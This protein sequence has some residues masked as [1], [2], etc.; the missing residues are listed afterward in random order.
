MMVAP[1]PFAAL[2]ASEHGLLVAG[3]AFVGLAVAALVYPFV[4]AYTQPRR[5]EYRPP[6]EVRR[7]KR[8]REGNATFRLF[9]PLVDELAAS[10]APPPRVLDRMQHDL[11]LTEPAA[12]WKAAEYFAIR[13]IESTY[14]AGG[15]ALLGYVIFDNLLLAIPIG[16]VGAYVYPFLQLQLLTGRA[17][18]Y[19]LAL[20]SRLSLVADLV[21][22]ML[23][24]AATLPQAIRTAAEENRGH[25][26][27]DELARVQQAVEKME[28]PKDALW[29]MA[30][31][32]ESPDLSELVFM[33]KTALERGTPLQDALRDMAE[34]LRTRRVLRLERAAEEAKVKI[35][36][37]ALLIMVA[38]LAI[39]T[40][41][42]LLAG[43]NPNP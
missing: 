35:S 26:V 37:P 7:R 9:E 22:L 25:P 3:S 39:I 29:A 6:E 1:P 27:G 16:L 14:V 28:A 33:I 19:R 20:E 2:A 40:A 4:A 43:A 24:G 41:P 42:F 23:E 36:G 10:A 18:E 5:D 11:D 17:R 21:A 15:I 38:C 31:R 12:N 8:L 30:R 13:R 34:R 32:V